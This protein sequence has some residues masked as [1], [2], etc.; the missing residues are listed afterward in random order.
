MGE[1]GSDVATRVMNWVGL[2]QGF[3]KQYGVEPALIL[4]QIQEE[5]GGNPDAFPEDPARDGASFGLMQLLL[6]TARALGYGGTAK[7]LFDPVV[8]VRLGTEYI[9]SLIKQ[10]GSDWLALIGYNGGPRAVRAYKLG[11]KF[12]AAVHYANVVFAL[13]HYY[14]RRL[15]DLAAKPPA[16]T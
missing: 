7:D 15:T 13:T 10:Y 11:Y 8:S 1:P 14:Q 5:S 6:P 16:A 4:A 12:G 3:G 2:A 9:G